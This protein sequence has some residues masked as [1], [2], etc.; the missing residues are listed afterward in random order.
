MEERAAGFV[1]S[2]AAEEGGISLLHVE[3][4]QY[5]LKDCFGELGELLRLEKD[6]HCVL[7]DADVVMQ[8]CHRSVRI[9]PCISRW[10]CVCCTSTSAYID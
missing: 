6:D 2:D 1:V 5:I 3:D 10:L 9:F 7:A 8:L 4:M